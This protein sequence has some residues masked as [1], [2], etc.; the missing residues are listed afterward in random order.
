LLV[1]ERDAQEREQR[2]E[3]REHQQ[4]VAV[5][6]RFREQLLKT[7]QFRRCSGRGVRRHEARIAADLAQAQKLSEGGKLEFCLAGSGGFEIE[8]FA[9]GLFLRVAVKLRLGGREFAPHDVFKFL[10]QFRRDGPLGAAQ[11]VGSGLGAKPIVE[12]R[13]LVA[14]QARRHLREIARQEE[15]KQ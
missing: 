8:E 1:V 15:L 7:F 3:L 14:A 11:D 4:A 10:R 13:S 9:L 5:V 12:P 6:D 2:R